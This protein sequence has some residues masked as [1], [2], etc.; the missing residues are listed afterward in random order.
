MDKIQKIILFDT[1]IF[2]KFL[3]GDISARQWMEGVRSHQ[4][5][6]GVSPLTDFELWSGLRNP[7]EERRHRIMVSQFRRLQFHTTIARR[8]GELAQPYRQKHD[9]SIDVVDFLLAATAEYFRAD[10]LTANPKHFEPL[11]LK[12]VTIIPLGKDPSI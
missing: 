4:V 11:P 12:G 7:G 9:K 5:I 3:R 6:G 8:A 1:N 10:I 2:I